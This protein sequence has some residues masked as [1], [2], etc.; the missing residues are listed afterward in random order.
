[1]KDKLEI[2][3]AK[4]NLSASALAKMLGV[5]ASAISHIKS[6][7]NKPSYDFVV[8]ILRAFPT[9]NPDWLLLDSPDIFR[10]T[11]SMDM[12]DAAIASDLTPLPQVSLFDEVENIGSSEINSQTKNECSDILRSVIK[13][14]KSVERV[15]VLY[16]DGSFDSYSSR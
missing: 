12:P 6:G 14:G 10:T 8:K 13:G 9:V 4:M 2:L 7:R 3:R 16:S 11:P 5:E 1:M 15:L